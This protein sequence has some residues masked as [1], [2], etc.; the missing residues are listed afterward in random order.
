MLVVYTID[1]FYLHTIVHKPLQVHYILLG[2]PKT[3]YL[4][5]VKV[6][7]LIENFVVRQFV[8]VCTGYS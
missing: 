2:V 8:Y 6:Q 5:K 3:Q 4:K 7:S 1:K